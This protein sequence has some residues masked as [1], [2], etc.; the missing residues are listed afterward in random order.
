MGK[1][2][3]CH[4]GLTVSDMDRTIDFY[5][6][7]FGFTVGERGVFS[8]EFIGDK[9]MLYR[10]ER[11]AYSDFAFLSSPDGVVLELF[12]FVPSCKAE[13]PVWNRPGYHHICIKVE[14]CREMYERMCA[15]GL[16]ELYYFRPDKMD[17]GGEHHWV[18]LRDPDGNMIEL[19]D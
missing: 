16:E 8:P 2:S 14:S 3:F 4:V 1:I 13:Q 9:P 19:Q 10:Q 6:K 11:G 12:R 17:A 5:R 15:D 18:F 7:Y